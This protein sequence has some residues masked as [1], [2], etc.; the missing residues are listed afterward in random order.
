MGLVRRNALYIAR[1]LSFK[2]HAHRP[3]NGIRD[4]RERP[5]KFQ[6]SPSISTA[7][8]YA[9]IFARCSNQR[10]TQPYVALYR[11]SSVPSKQV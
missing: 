8:S 9:I 11:G 1:N 7:E 4:E 5:F 10:H 2:R 6:L 3:F